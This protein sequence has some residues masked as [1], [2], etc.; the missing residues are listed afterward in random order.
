MGA[1]TPIGESGNF[2]WVWLRQNYPLLLF[3]EIQRNFQLAGG[4]INQTLHQKSA[5]PDNSELVLLGL[6]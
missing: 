4:L 2:D 3:C 1:S 5:H 6:E